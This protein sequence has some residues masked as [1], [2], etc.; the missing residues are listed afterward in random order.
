MSRPVWSR[1]SNGQLMTYTTTAS[2]KATTIGK[3]ILAP[4][5]QYAN[6]RPRT[7]FLTICPLS[8]LLDDDYVTS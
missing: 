4:Y 3:A 5:Q 1:R 8:L 7:P 6:I 2:R